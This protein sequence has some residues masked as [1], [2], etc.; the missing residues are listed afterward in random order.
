MTTILD[1]EI[2]MWTGFVEGCS[3]K[4]RNCPPSKE[5]E[6]IKIREAHQR[7]LDAML[8]IKRMDEAA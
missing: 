4:I 5:N 1:R 6:L 8:A 7:V 2:D 3:R